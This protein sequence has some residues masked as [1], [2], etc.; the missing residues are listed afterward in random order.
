VKGE[1]GKADQPLR[2]RV[3]ASREKKKNVDIYFLREGD[4]SS[5]L[6]N[7]QEKGSRTLN[8]RVQERKKEK[9]P[10]EKRKK[11]AASA[12]ADSV[13]APDQSAWPS[14]PRCGKKPVRNSPP[15]KRKETL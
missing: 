13:T 1:K 12:M 8:N 9:K 15:Q 14:T 3:W 11:N 2:E 10:F 6:L 4:C 5:S 7:Q